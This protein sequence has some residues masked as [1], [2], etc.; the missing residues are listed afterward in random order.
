MNIRLRLE[1][2]KKRHAGTTV[3]KGY[4]FLHTVYNKRTLIFEFLHGNKKLL[5]SLKKTKKPVA[6]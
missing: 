3:I 5:L 2:V 1:L 6:F 4:N